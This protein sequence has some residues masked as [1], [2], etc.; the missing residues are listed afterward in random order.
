M[1]VVQNLRVVDQSESTVLQAEN[2]QFTYAEFEAL[3]D[4]PLLRRREPKTMGKLACR[5]SITLSWPTPTGEVRP[6]YLGAG[7]CTVRATVPVVVV[8]PDVPVT[9]IV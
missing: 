5:Q 6:F 4:H 2:K 1:K 8:D 7:Y 3:L 9:V